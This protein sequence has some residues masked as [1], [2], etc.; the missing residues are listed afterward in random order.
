MLNFT[1]KYAQTTFDPYVFARDRPRLLNESKRISLDSLT[2][3]DALK[4]ELFNISNRSLA[5]EYAHRN[6]TLSTEEANVLEY[7]KTMYVAVLNK[8]Y[9]P[10]TTPPE[11]EKYQTHPWLLILVGVTA[12]VD[13]ELFF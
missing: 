4:S 1:S 2:S 13:L 11:L 12:V 6:H 7:L 9:F 10:N 5:I 8:L 3:T